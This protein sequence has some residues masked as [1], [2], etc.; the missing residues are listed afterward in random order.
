MAR[1]LII[2]TNLLLLLVIGAV[3]EGRHIGT[4]KRLNAFN[5]EDYDNVLEFMKGYSSVYITPYIAA[6]VSNLIDLDGRAGVKAYLVARELFDFFSQIDVSI[7]D[8]C[9]SD[10]YLRFGIADSSI[11]RLAS[12][13]DIFTY[14]NRMLTALYEVSPDAIFPYYPVK[15]R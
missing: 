6:E 14:D 3:E 7:S 2:D 9:A 5:I 8:D 10:Y 13:Y 12:D 15:G 11:I 1:G 4:S